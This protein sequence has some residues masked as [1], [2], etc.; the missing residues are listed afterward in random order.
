MSDKEKYREFPELYAKINTENNSIDIQIARL[1]Y[2]PLTFEEINIPELLEHLADKLRKLECDLA[3]AKMLV[4]KIDKI[5][6][7]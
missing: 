5:Q 4:M 3:E 7:E 6:K 2:L 1:F